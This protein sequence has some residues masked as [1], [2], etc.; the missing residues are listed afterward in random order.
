MIRRSLLHFACALL[1]LVAQHGAI[2]H[3][4]WHLGK[5]APAQSQPQ[6]QLHAASHSPDSDRSPQSRLCDLH[7][8]MGSL[9]TGDCGS[10]FVP[11][12]AP[13]SHWLATSA[14]VWH[15]AQPLL[16]PPSRAPPVLL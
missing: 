5:H 11:D 9:L 6:A 7:F 15:V 1:L 14:A 8:A 12:A 2:T 10:Q 3:S 13:L 16:T 4:V